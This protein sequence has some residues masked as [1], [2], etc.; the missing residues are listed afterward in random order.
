MAGGFDLDRLAMRLA[1]E[2]GKAW[3]EMADFPG[4]S[5][6]IWREA[7]RLAVARTMPGVIVEDLPPDFD[8]REGGWRVHL[9]A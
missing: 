3:Q 4:Y 5:R 7:A 8:G 2:Q 1:A 9:P 6:N